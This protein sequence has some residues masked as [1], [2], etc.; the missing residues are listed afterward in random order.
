[1]RTSS[2]RISCAVIFFC[3]TFKMSHAD[4]WPAACLITIRTTQL[5]FGTHEVARGVTDVGVGSGALFGVCKQANTTEPTRARLPLTPSESNALR[6][7]EQEAVPFL[8]RGSNARKPKMCDARRFH[9]GDDSLT[10]DQIWLESARCTLARSTF[11]ERQ[12]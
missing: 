10:D 4:I 3:L 5:Q 9:L 8:L 12:R 11:A 2:L 7:L 6:P 1:M